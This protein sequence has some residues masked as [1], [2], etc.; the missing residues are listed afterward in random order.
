ML[1]GLSAAPYF[2]DVP[3]THPFFAQIQR[4]K[5]LGITNGCSAD[6]PRY[7]PDDTVTRGQL[8]AFLIRGIEGGAP[9]ETASNEETGF[10]VFG[11]RITPL[12]AAGGLLILAAVL[13]R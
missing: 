12:M 1:V 10:V 13:R 8:A 3:S 7:C 2:E 9:V 5:D 4:M 11:Q 6:P